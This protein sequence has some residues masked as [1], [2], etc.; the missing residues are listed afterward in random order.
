MGHENAEKEKPKDEMED[1]EYKTI[2]YKVALG[3]PEVLDTIV[4]LTQPKEQKVQDYIVKWST[5]AQHDHQ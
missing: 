2:L 1:M 5:T 4:G 3:R